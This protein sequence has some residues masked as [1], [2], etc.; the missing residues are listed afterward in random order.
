M[1]TEQQIK[2]KL[3]KLMADVKDAEY[4]VKGSYPNEIFPNF[5]AYRHANSQIQ[6][7]KWVLENT[8]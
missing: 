6:T 1:K 7:L 4:C 2:D 8:K 5:S 3:L